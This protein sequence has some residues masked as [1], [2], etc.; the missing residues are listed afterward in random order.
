MDFDGALEARRSREDL[1]VLNRQ[2]RIAVNDARKHVA[3]RLDAQ[4]QR[5]HIQQEQA[6]DVA[7]QHA[8]LKRRADGDALVGIDP[9]ERLLAGKALD[10]LLHGGNAR[11][12]AD[13]QHL[14]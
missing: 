6:L 5:R 11:R 4:R 10:G 12:S 8:A 3:H 9:L 2:R 14:A 13:E 7:A 1:A